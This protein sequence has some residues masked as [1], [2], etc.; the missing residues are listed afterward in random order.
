MACRARVPRSYTTT[1]IWRAAASDRAIYS[2]WLVSGARAR[3]C[4]LADARVMRV[5]AVD[6]DHENN[7]EKKKNP[8]G[9]GGGDDKEWDGDDDDDVDEDEESE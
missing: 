1:T 3:V 5:R 9:G 4:A 6:A 7:N 2:G 8:L